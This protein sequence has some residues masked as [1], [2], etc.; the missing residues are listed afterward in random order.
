MRVIIT[1]IGLLFLAACGGGGGGSTSASSGASAAYNFT[2]SNTYFG[3]SAYIRDYGTYSTSGARGECQPSAEGCV[4]GAEGQVNA[5]TDAITF[6]SDWGINESNFSSGWTFAASDTASVA[7]VSTANNLTTTN[8]NYES[9]DSANGYTRKLSV[10]IPSNFSH[11][12]WLY[13]DNTHALHSYCLLY[14]SPSP[15][16]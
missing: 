1:F 7:T 13:W 3:P 6:Y 2:V 15:R 14:T 5:D 4:I 16:D 10:L 11:Q 8:Y 9:T 12:V